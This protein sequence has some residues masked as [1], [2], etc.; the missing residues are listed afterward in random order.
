MKI[1]KFT[2]N[3]FGVNTY[4]IWDEASGEAA[5]I[6]PGM[7]SRNDNS[8]LE[9]FILSN[10]L[11]PKFLINTHLHIDHTLGNDAVMATYSLPIHANSDD[12][13][14]GATR[15]R[16]A[17]MF[18][19]GMSSLTPVSVDHNL[20]NGD[21]LKLG[22]ETIEIIAVP[23]HSP[24]SIAIYSPDGGFVITGDALFQGSIGRTD[25]PGGNHSQ[26]IRSITERLLS[27][28]PDTIVYPGH[29]PS[30]TIGYEKRMNPFL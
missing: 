10:S 22:N 24:G 3:M 8:E 4:V 29:G 20:K 1:Q 25:L 11:T 9:N 19:I 30:T 13:F 26:L 14:L 17:E 5:I 7:I 15:S 28:P 23:G 27:L 21:R 18:G 6:D 16:Q 12:E 2:Y